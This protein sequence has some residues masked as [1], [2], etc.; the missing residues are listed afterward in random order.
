MSGDGVGSRKF[1]RWPPTY[2]VHC[3]VLVSRVLFTY[4]LLLVSRSSQLDFFHANFHLLRSST[5]PPPHTHAHTCHSPHSSHGRTHSHSELDR[6]LR[7]KE[8]SLRSAREAHTSKLTGMEEQ[9]SHLTGLLQT[10]D[11]EVGQL[12]SQLEECRGEKDAQIK[13]WEDLLHCIILYAQT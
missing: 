1:K 2:T 4:T 3:T 10:K 5:P 12:H 6:R 9:I 8:T 11:S 13:R 7:E